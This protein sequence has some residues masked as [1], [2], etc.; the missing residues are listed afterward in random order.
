MGGA[1]GLPQVGTSFLALLRGFPSVGRWFLSMGR[2]VLILG[3]VVNAIPKLGRWSPQSVSRDLAH[4]VGDP[5]G[6]LG[7]QGLLQLMQTN[8]RMKI[9]CLRTQRIYMKLL[10]QCLAQ[11]ACSRNGSLPI[12]SPQAPLGTSEAFMFSTSRLYTQLRDRHGARS[13]DP[14]IMT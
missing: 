11:E 12:P 4:P 13:H 9:L 14:Q 3:E 5:S 7:F 2:G 8:K 1:A 10:P 6:T